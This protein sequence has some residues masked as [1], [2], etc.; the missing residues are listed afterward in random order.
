M[1][2]TRLGFNSKAVITGDVTQIDLP[3]A[4]R[5]GLIEAMEVLKNVEGLAFVHF[6]ETD[7]VRHQLVQRIVHAYDE[8]KAR[9]EQQMLPL[10]E[11]RNGGPRFVETTSASEKRA[12]PAANGSVA[13]APAENQEK[14]SAEAKG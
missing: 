2:V 11:P 12:A 4:R 14:P 9:A 8:H 13:N 10:A 7:V 5:S 1:F 6:D 3:N